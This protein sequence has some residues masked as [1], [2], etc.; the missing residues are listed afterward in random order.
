MI[1]CEV[2]CGSFVVVCVIELML[3][4]IFDMIECELVDF[5]IVCIVYMLEYD[6]VWCGVC[7]VLVGIDD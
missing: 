2:G 1:C 5:L 6:V 7:V 4:Y 3:N